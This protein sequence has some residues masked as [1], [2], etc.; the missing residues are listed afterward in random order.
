MIGFEA[1]YLAH[2]ATLLELL[3]A[4]A[5]AGVVP[6]DLRV[7]AADGFGTAFCRPEAVNVSDGLW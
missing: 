4:A 5:R 2:P 7:F 3:S 6:T 1:G